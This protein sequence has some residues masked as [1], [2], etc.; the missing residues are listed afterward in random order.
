MINMN[1]FDKKTTWSNLEFIPFKICI[2]TAY[3]LIGMYFHEYVKQ[4]KTLIIILFV[5]TWIVTMYMWLHKMK[6]E[7]K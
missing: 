5:F 6:Q 7:N 4:Y 1:I 2:G 3:L